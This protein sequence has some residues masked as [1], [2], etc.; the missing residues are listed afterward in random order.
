MLFKKYIVLI[1]F[2]FSALSSLAQ[3]EI[4]A[5][6]YNIRLDIA[7]DG[8][9]RWDLRKDKVAGL[10]NYYEADFIGMQEVLLNQLKY[11]QEHLIE[12]NFIGVGRDDGKEAGEFSC[13]F[14]KK[15]EFNVIQQST[16]WLSPTPDSP[17]KAWD[18][19]Y[20][21]VCTYGL[22]QD[23]KTKQRFWVFNTH[24]DHVGKTAR[25]ESA[26]LIIERIHELNNKNFPVILMGDFNS[27]PEEP[28]VEYII[29][30]MDNSRAISKMVHG[31]ADTWNAFKFHE[32][33]N[34]CID[35]V[36]VSKDKKITVSKFI[37]ITD[38]YDLKY[39]S[40]H[41]PVMATIVINK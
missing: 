19:A 36:F 30:N 5:M 16:F 24:F 1:L 13:I 10:M 35:Y 31:P 14:F 40:D 34:G 6:S 41:L 3:T 29:A 22:F 7:S 33:P 28:P 38:S 32:K 39:P 25:L 8:D 26:K 15:D 18:A 17:S 12:Y 20:K 11:L 23:K 9:N 27:R 4:K 2:F 21:R 37:T